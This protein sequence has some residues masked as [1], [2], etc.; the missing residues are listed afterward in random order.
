M[1]TFRMWIVL[2][3]SQ[4]YTYIQTRQIV[5]TKNIVFFVSIMYQ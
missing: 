5:D 2:M 4:V 3:F 1:D